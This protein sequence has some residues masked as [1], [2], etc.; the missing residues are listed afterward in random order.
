MPTAYGIGG[1]D[2]FVAALALALGW[3][4][5]IGSTLTMLFFPALLGIVEGLRHRKT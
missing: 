2:G 5:M 3:G 1:H 4:L